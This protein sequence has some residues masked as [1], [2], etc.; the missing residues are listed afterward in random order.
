MKRNI[1]FI[2][3]VCLAIIALLNLFVGHRILVGSA[4]IGLLIL[5]TWLYFFTKEK[6]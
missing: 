1:P 4:S 3:A 5:V 6:E 2:G